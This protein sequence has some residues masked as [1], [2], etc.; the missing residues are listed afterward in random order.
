MEHFLIEILSKN[1][2]IEGL[3]VLKAPHYLRLE[4]NS[5]KLC[6]LTAM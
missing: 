2:L 4:T 6:L 5:A 3:I 1:L